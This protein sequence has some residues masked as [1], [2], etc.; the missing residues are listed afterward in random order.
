M[1]QQKNKKFRNIKEIFL[2]AEIFFSVNVLFQK[3]NEN[4]FNRS[5]HAMYDFKR[6]KCISNCFELVRLQY[7]LK[8]G[9]FFKIFIMPPNFLT[10]FEGGDEINF[11]KYFKRR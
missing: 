10:D 9:F 8:F 6:R 7:S 4:I 3:K 1:Y 5:R 2:F 11:E